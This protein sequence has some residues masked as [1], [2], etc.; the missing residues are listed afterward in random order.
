MAAITAAGDGAVLSHWSAASL[1]RMR[2]GTRTAESWHGTAQA[3]ETPDD[4]V[5]PRAPGAGRSQRRTGHPGNH[6][7]EDTARS[8]AVPTQRRARTHDRS[9]TPEREVPPWRSLLRRYPGR[10]GVPKLRAALAEPTPMTRSDLEATAGR[11]HATGGAA[12][13]GSERVSR[14]LRGRLRLARARSDR[15]TRHLHDPR[16]ANRLR[17][18]PPTRPEARDRRMDGRAP[19]GGE[20]NRR[21][22]PPSRRQRSTFTTPSRATAA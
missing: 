19:N 7:G 14:G 21:P 9:L 12:A 20:R 3:E 13:A 10:A 15:R 4:R 2:P 11:G 8:R 6:A 1:W 5:P 18:R 22:Q 16:I 17:A